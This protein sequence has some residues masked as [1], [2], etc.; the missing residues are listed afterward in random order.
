MTYLIDTNIILEVRKGARCNARVSAWYASITD[1][2]LFLST[3]VLGE[4][5]K[6]IELARRRDAGQA[7]A[8][9]RWLRKVET[10][11]G[12]RVLGIDNAISDQ[13]GRISAIR[14]VPVID[15][16]LVATALTNGLTLVTRNDR[17]VADLGATVL[18]P[19]KDGVD[20][21]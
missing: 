18:N 12:E 3:L 5:R 17:D 10:A 7:A 20:H 1:E 4:I 6:G 15:G 16:L 14:P 13:W 21:D 19:F 11:F 8:L 9:E 2:D